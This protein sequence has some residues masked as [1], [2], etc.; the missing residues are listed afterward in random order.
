MFIGLLREKA[1]AEKHLFWDFMFLQGTV[2]A[3]VTKPP[4]PRPARQWV[5]LEE[6]EGR[7]G[8]SPPLPPAL[9]GLKLARARP[10]R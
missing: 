9:L 3:S 7:A 10:L 5:T 4:L 6:S 1:A 2:P 8:P